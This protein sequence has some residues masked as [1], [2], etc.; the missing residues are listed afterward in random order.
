MYCIWHALAWAAYPTRACRIENSV[1]ETTSPHIRTRYNMTWSIGLPG[2]CTVR[3]P[4]PCQFSIVV[5]PTPDIASEDAA[6]PEMSSAS[7]AQLRGCQLCQCSHIGLRDSATDPAF[8]LS[9]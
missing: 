4:P 3:T 5:F 6:H 1:L 9:Y 8:G 2:G 7:G